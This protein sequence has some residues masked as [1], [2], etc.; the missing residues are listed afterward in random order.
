MRRH[1]YILAVGALLL[2]VSCLSGGEAPGA[3]SV[4]EGGLGIGIYEPSPPE[5]LLQWAGF[6]DAGDLEV[7]GADEECGMD[8]HA[9]LALRGDPSAI[10]AALVAAD[11][12]VP[13]TPGLGLS[14]FQTPLEGVDLKSLSD[15]VSAEQ[16]SWEN[17]A[18]E[19]LV[20][21]YVR[22][23]QAGGQEVLHVWA[24]TT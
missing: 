9:R 12:T 11:F 10:D 8:A 17:S 4:E 23:A 7:I 21:R 24:F 20:R 2:M 18:G 19:R 5:D 14:V 16:Q 1:W 3:C 13:P 22:G 6:K 15:V